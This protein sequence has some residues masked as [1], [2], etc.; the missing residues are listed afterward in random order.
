MPKWVTISSPGDLPDPGIELLF[1]TLQADFFFFFYLLSHLDHQGSRPNFFFFFKHRLAKQTTGMLSSHTLCHLCKFLG[2]S[3]LLLP[4][5][6]NLTKDKDAHS[7]GGGKKNRAAIV[8][9]LIHLG[10]Y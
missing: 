5:E 9:P 2:L 1:P 3:E 6:K 8:K 4:H 7:Q 10:L